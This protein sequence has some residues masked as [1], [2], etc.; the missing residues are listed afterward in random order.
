[1]D[2]AGPS[3]ISTPR[4]VLPAATARERPA[5]PVSAPSVAKARWRPGSTSAA[6]PPASPVSM[7]TGSPPPMTETVAPATGFPSRVTIPSMVPAEASST[8]RSRSA[9]TATSVRRPVA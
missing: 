3:R 2:A 1:M 9:G 4:S 8:T 7:E 6:K 5:E